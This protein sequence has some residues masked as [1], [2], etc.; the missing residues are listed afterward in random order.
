MKNQI[1]IKSLLVLPVFI[2]GALF[3]ATSCSESKTSDSREVAKEENIARLA[4]NNQ[5]IVVVEN[6]NDTQFLMDAA[7]M[8]LEEINLG[9]L[10]QQKGTSPQVKELGKIMEDDHTKALNE[11]KALAQSKSVTIP[12]SITNDSKDVYEKLADKTGNDFDEAY[13]DLMVEHHEDAIDLFEK[14]STDSKDAEIRAW[15]S[16]KLA[17]LRTHL[18]KVEAL[19]N[20]MKK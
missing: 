18:V 4:S 20:N 3:M 19:E 5:T 1:N 17:G 16:Q 10:A 9:K 12:T 14:G 6:D 13:S 2:A 7:E 15:A 11:L 8:Q